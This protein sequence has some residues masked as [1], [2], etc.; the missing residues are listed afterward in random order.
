M[1]KAYFFILCALTISLTA[2]AQFKSIKPSKEITT[3]EYNDFKDFENLDLANDFKAYVTFTDGPESIKIEANENLHEYI[4]VEME[5]N[6]LV[7]KFKST[8]SI[9]GNETLH[10][11]ISTR[12]LRNFR[13]SAD[14]YIY[15]ENPLKTEKAKITLRGDSQLKGDIEVNDLY[16]NLRGD[17]IIKLAGKADELDAELRGD[18]I[19]EDGDFTA[20]EAT[21]K[22]RGDSVVD[23]DVTD[24]LWAD[25]DGDSVLQYSGT[26]QIMRSRITGDSEM[27]QKG[28]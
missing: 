20:K 16:L 13:A 11:Y 23:I 17:S 7:I 18:S 25:L 2:T 5:G 15:F 4:T 14:A 28:N 9:R 24:K 8:W 6:T 12:Q 3:K 27:E 10:A 26:P 1:R 19:M 21:L 22:L